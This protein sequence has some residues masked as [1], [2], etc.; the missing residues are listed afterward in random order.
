MGKSHSNCFDLTDTVINP[1][2]LKFYSV[3]KYKR[4]FMGG[5]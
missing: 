4:I 5:W 2:L 3:A 1:A